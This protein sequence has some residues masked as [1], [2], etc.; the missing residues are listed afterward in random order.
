[1]SKKWATYTVILSPEE[2]YPVRAD[3]NTTAVQT[4]CARLPA[5]RFAG[6]G[7]QV[8]CMSPEDQQIDVIVRFDGDE[9]QLG[10]WMNDAEPR[11]MSRAE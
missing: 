10:P 1:M 11:Y 9:L 4:I 6:D 7:V 5:D 2:Q 8:A 3:S